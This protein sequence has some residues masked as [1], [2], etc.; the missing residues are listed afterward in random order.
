M[1]PRGRGARREFSGLHSLVGAPYTPIVINRF[2]HYGSSILYLKYFLA[3][4]LLCASTHSAHA[5]D[6]HPLQSQDLNGGSYSFDNFFI[7]GG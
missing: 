5:M 7:P 1:A 6:F 3:G 4:M 2:K